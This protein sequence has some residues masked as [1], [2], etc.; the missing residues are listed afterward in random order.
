[1]AIEN[2]GYSRIGSWFLYV[3][4]EYRPNEKSNGLLRCCWYEISFYFYFQTISDKNKWKN[5]YHSHSFVNDIL[6][7]HRH[8]HTQK[9]KHIQQINDCACIRRFISVKTYISYHMRMVLRQF[10][11]M[12]FDFTINIDLY[13]IFCIEFGRTKLKYRKRI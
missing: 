5:L 11:P 8:T 10:L 3:P 12:N 6:C 7:I 1:M 9:C 4:D 13:L 2:Q